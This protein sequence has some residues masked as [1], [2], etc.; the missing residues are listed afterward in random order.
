[1]IVVPRGASLSAANPLLGVYVLER[2]VLAAP[3]SASYA[4]FDVSDDD[5]MLSPVQVY[6]PSGEQ[7]VD[8]ELDRVGDLLAGH[9]AATWSVPALETLGRHAIRWTVATADGTRTFSEEFD[10]AAGVVGGRFRG[11]A[12]PSDLRAEG[13]GVDVSEVRIQ[14]ALATSAAFIERVTSRFFDPRALSLSLDGTGDPVLRFSVPVIA[15]SSVDY[16]D[17]AGESAAVDL[18]GLRVY[19]RWI[20]EGLTNPDDRDDPRAEWAWRDFPAAIGSGC[21]MWREG[22]KNVRV[23]GLF[24]Y[25]DPGDNYVGDTPVR[26]RHLAAMLALRELP[27]AWGDAGLRDEVRNRHRILSETTRDQSYTLGRDSR[28]GAQGG[29]AEFT[30]DPDLDQILIEFMAP[31]FV[32]SP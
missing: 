3:T 9:Y 30:G 12:L 8:P 22:R 15:V 7:A 1:M 19:N 14:R 16:L 5:R 11:Y 20:T 13:V 18:A 21:Y 26:I 2:G 6:P 23:R 4:I 32:G 27:A 28:L 17:D 10:V 31:P 25:T 24:G 29:G